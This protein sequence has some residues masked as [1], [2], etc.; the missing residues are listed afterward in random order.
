MA[1]INALLAHLELLPNFH[2]EK[3][4]SILP[5]FHGENLAAFQI[6]CVIV[7]K[8]LFSPSFRY[9]NTTNGCPI[10]KVKIWQSFTLGVLWRTAGFCTYVYGMC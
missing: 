3:S 7:H 5:Y 6:R 10:F 2:D 9:E 8:T 1:F 4:S